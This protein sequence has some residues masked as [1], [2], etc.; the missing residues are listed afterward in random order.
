MKNIVKN[1]MWLAGVFGILIFGFFLTGV[2]VVH[3]DSAKDVEGLYQEL[4]GR[5]SDPAG[6]DFFV[7]QLNS[8]VSLDSI[9]QDIAGS[10]EAQA[11]AASAP[12]TVSYAGQT[13][14]I[15][16]DTGAFTGG[17]ISGKVNLG[18]G[19]II[20]ESGWTGNLTDLVGATITQNV[21]GG[22]S[23]SAVI[24]THSYAY[25]VSMFVSGYAYVTAVNAGD[26][27]AIQSAFDFANR[28]IVLESA[29]TQQTVTTRANSDGSISYGCVNVQNTTIAFATSFEE[30][31]LNTNTGGGTPG[32]GTPGGGTPG[33]GTPDG[34]TR[35]G[36]PGGGNAG[37]S[38][39]EAAN[40]GN[41]G[42]GSDNN[43][44]SSSVCNRNGVCESGENRNNCPTDCGDLSVTIGSDGFTALPRTVT[45][46]KAVTLSWFAQGASAC[47]ITGKKAGSGQQFYS[48]S[49]SS[50]GSTVS[51]KLTENTDFT[52]S[53]SNGRN[54]T[55]TKT[56]R[57]KVIDPLFQEI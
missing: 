38:T 32:G 22:G 52:L 28:A 10:P 18:S 34:D 16:G 47:S 25:Q 4:L 12:M 6:F 49:G 51:P 2:N 31:P 36:G 40:G 44:S 26:E 45:V 15:D 3:A 5:N 57:V 37:G 13:Y 27:A 46:N 29:G 14:A 53:C 24:D 43:N 48:F 41:N 50:S 21:S 11:I 54:G 30:N 39:N 1:K 33:G 35:I 19:E 9:R 55:D 56:I 23:V 8:G 7:S 17:G 20:A 42:G